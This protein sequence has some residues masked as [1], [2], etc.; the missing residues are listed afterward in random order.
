MFRAGLQGVG[1]DEGILDLRFLYLRSVEHKYLYVDIIV[2]I[3][4]SGI[5]VC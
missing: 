2:Y 3:V 5:Y 4:Y 1:K